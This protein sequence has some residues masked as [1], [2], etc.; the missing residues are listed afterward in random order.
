MVSP[1]Q[2]HQRFEGR[3]PPQTS[4]ANLSILGHRLGHDWA[5]VNVAGAV[6]GTVKAIPVT[7]ARRARA[8]GSAKELDIRRASPRLGVGLVWDILHS[9]SSHQTQLQHEI[10]L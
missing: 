5:I 6:C 8:R 9:T 3:R 1:Q 2:R 7:L 10:T 4:D